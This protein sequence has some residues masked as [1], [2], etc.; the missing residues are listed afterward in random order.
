MSSE[1]A[2]SEPRTGTYL[3]AILRNAPLPGLAKL[4]GVDGRRVR[5]IEESG[6]TAVVSTVPFPAFEESALRQKLE[7]LDW[8]ESTARAHHA[9]V[10]TVARHA[11]TAPVS[12]VTVYNDDRRVRRLLSDRRTEIL[13]VLDRMTGRSEWGVKVYL[14]QAPAPTS[15]SA[16]PAAASGS[17]ERPGR[18][19]TNYLRQRRA[20]LH[21]REQAAR[22]AAELA[23]HLGT[24]LAR[25]AV[26][27]RQY[28]PQDPRLSGRNDWMILNAAYLVDDGSVA[29]FQAA[30]RS[31]D[32][33]AATVEVTGP[34][35]PYSF[36]TVTLGTLGTLGEEP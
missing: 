9:V 28:Q 29:D 16:A 23:E 27:S 19:G 3:Y 32:S 26:A 25:H 8:L 35:A 22:R 11:V 20:A 2:G 1:P 18:A 14:E 4:V 30:A 15:D 36:V 21:G 6:L 24:R 31:L 33:S 7:D 10:D 12:L 5:T 13:E 17:A 34:W